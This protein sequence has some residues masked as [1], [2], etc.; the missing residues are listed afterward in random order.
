VQHQALLVVSRLPA[1]F[2]PLYW[3]CL[4][5]L[6]QQ[7]A[8]WRQ[9]QHTT[10]W[11]NLSADPRTAPSGDVTPCA[12][13]AWFDFEQHPH[14][15]P[16]SCIWA[17]NVPYSQL[18]SLIKLYKLST[19]SHNLD[20]ERMHHARPRVPRSRKACPWCCVPDGLH[21]ELHARWRAPIFPTPAS[22]IRP[23]LAAGLV[24]I[25]MRTLFIAKCLAPT[26]S[27]VH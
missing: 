11:G 16:P 26:A 12:Y 15:R 9:H 27:F 3:H 6:C 10:V 21:D 19:N 2:N 25:D 7:S 20:F 1:H 24:G 22:S 13:D 4:S 17:T 18:I 5:S 8:L 23:F 14:W